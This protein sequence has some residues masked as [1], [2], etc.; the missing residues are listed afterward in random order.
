MKIFL[1]IFIL[2]TGSLYSQCQG[3]LNNDGFKNVSDIVALVSQILS[4]DTECEEEIV[5]GCLDP[6]ACNYD[7]SALVDDGSCQYPNENF[8]CEGNC[9]VDIDCA[10]DCGGSAL[11][12]S[13]T[14]VANE[15][16]Y[17]QSNGTISMIS[18]QGEVYSTENLGQT[19]QSIEVYNNKLIVLVNG[20]SKMKIYD[21]STSGL[22]MPGIEIDL[23]GSSPR[24]MTIIGDKLYFTNWNSQDIK[25][26]NLF[27][28]GIESS[29]SVSGLPE[30]IEYDGN[31]LWVT[32]P[33]A[34]SYFSTGSTICKIDPSL[35]QLIETYE[36]GDG[37][38]Q[39]A[40]NGNEV[41]VSRTFYD[42]SWNTFHGASKLSES[43]DI[44]INNYG[45][46]A[47]CGGAVINHNSNMMRSSGGGLAIMDNNLDLLP[48]SIGN[49]QQWQVY[50]IEK[51]QGNFWFALTD[52]SDFNEV[53]V[54]DDTGQ[55][56]SVFQVG[57]NPG[58]FAFWQN[59]D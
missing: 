12:C 35:N 17:G 26:F 47:P 53:H 34:D 45:S 27:T 10:G 39:V 54:L 49:F 59:N 7:V 38:Q 50:H 1:T 28:Y 30:D 58:D 33:H 46:G 13:W 36:V 24:E 40:F 44:I 43:G 22:S 8:D 18:D 14:F 6:E 21:I 31:Y 23:N 16:N 52:F 9:L 56:V 20:D 48:V 29:I 11:S 4:G 57:I 15:G 2:I 55:E 19:V 25:V 41:F 3:D 51:I 32:I 37:P 42:S 5:Y